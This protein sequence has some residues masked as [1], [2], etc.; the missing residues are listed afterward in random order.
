[1]STRDVMTVHP[2]RGLRW[3]RVKERLAEWRQRS[4]SRSELGHFSE[5][6]LRDIGLSRE[7]ADCE[8]SKPFWMV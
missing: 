7:A 3:R 2:R 5:R 4:R 1:M 8:A 6:T